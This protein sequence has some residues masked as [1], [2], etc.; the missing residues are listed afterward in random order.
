LILAFAVIF[1]AFH[2]VALLLLNEAPMRTERAKPVAVVRLPKPPN[3]Y[4]MLGVDPLVDD[5][6]LRQIKKKFNRENHPVSKHSK[7]AFIFLMR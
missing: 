3:Y 6:T 2:T 4:E 7:A 1:V 5:K